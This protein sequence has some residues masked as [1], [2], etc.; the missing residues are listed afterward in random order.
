MLRVTSGTALFPTSVE[1]GK[2]HQM[3]ISPCVFYQATDTSPNFFFFSERHSCDEGLDK[4]D[5]MDSPPNIPNLSQKIIPDTKPRVAHCLLVI[6]L[7]KR[8][9]KNKTGL[10]FMP[11]GVRL[12]FDHKLLFS[13]SVDM[14]ICE[15]HGLDPRSSGMGGQ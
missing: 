14:S 9:R 8:E 11:Q 13:G 3:G 7:K 4:D 2:V 15:L 1:T 6:I 10:L 5:F 12:S